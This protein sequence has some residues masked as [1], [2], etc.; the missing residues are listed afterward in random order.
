MHDKGRVTRRDDPVM[1][2]ADT[3]AL[4][5]LQQSYPRILKRAYNFGRLVFRAIIN[6][7]ELE[8]DILLTQDAGY[9]LVNIPSRIVGG[10]GD[11]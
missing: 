6:D 10:H 7:H 11:G 1:T 9:G 5:I 3:F 8:I 4:T 2:K